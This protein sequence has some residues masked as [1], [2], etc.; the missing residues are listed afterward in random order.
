M[1]HF[2]SVRL[3]ILSMS[4]AEIDPDYLRLIVDNL[5][6]GMDV[7]RVP[8]E[9]IQYVFEP[10]AE[11]KEKAIKIGRVDTVKRIQTIVRQTII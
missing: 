2:S 11:E 7:A 6:S 3:K 8:V 1:R 9:Y 4:S 5:I 10:L